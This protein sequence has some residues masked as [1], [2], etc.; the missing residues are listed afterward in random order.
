[1]AFIGIVGGG[2]RGNFIG[3]RIQLCGGRAQADAARDA[4][5]LTAEAQRLAALRDDRR[6]EIAQF[7]QKARETVSCAETLYQRDHEGNHQAAIRTVYLELSQNKQSL[8]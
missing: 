6:R 1:M 8:N 5:R 2:I 3:A 4:A 7:V